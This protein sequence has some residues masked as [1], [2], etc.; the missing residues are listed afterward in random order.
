MLKTLALVFALIPVIG[1]AAASTKPVVHEKV[2][3]LHLFFDETEFVDTLTL[4]HQSDGR[5]SGTMH[6][7]QDFDAPV[8]NLVL[9][10]KIIEF[11]V[12]VPKNKA[13]PADLIFHYKGQFY[14]A[15]QKQISGFVNVKDQSP[16]TAAFVAFLRE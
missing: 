1:H 11:D 14:S 16:F 9:N 15:D 7:P 12:L 3:G 5:L 6:V 8:S 2:Y 13:R 4:Q 10:E